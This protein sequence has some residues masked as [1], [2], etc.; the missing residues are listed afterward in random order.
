MDHKMWLL[1]LPR[2]RRV[3]VPSLPLDHTH[4]KVVI[5]NKFRRA[6]RCVECW[7]SPFCFF[8]T[9]IVYLPRNVSHL[10]LEF[11]K[12]LPS[13]IC[14]LL[15]IFVAVVVCKIKILNDVVAS[16]R[17]V[18]HHANFSVACLPRVLLFKRR[19]FA[20]VALSWCVTCGGVRW[21]ELRR[22]LLHM[23]KF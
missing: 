23:V 10:S 17:S 3:R 9:S 1:L 20:S 15:T 18:L 5:S 6:V 7:P 19:V 11:P 14:A 16:V 13:Y 21:V 4:Q 2:V 12:I 8:F 22:R